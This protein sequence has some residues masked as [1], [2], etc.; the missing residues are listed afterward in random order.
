MFALVVVCFINDKIV[1]LV[2]S[3]RAE[4]VVTSDTSILCFHNTCWIL[5]AAEGKESFHS[6]PPKVV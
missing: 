3:L 1:K 2:I 5:H 4:I 6:L